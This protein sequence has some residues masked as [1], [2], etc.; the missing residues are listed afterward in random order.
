LTKFQPAISGCQAGSF[1]RLPVFPFS[2]ASA[3]S[4]GEPYK[5]FHQFDKYCRT[6]YVD[7]QF[8][9]V[10]GD[11]INDNRRYSQYHKHNV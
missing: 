8:E 6:A 4:V 5:K 10:F 7:K 3:L 9:I 11:E 1:C 2:L